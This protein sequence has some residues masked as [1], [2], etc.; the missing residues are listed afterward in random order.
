MSYAREE[1]DAKRVTR[2]NTL[3]EDLQNG[4][5]D[6]PQSAKRKRQKLTRTNVKK[7]ADR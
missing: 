7:E 2:P 3:A 4:P 1:R 6:G 5:D